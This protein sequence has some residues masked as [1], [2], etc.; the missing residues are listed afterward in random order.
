VPALIGMLVPGKHEKDSQLVDGFF[1]LLLL[2]LLRRRRRLPLL[3]SSFF[4]LLSSFFFIFLSFSVTKTW[5]WLDQPNHLT[6]HDTPAGTS[7]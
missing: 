6:A 7:C 4:F 5:L 2:L 1:F 3:S